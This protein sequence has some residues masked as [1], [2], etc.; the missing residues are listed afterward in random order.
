MYVEHRLLIR[1]RR[2]LWTLG[3]VGL[4]LLGVF[5]YFRIRGLTETSPGLAHEHA[6]DIVALE[7]ALGI[8]WEDELQALVTP[9]DFL[10][11]FANWIYIW[12]HWPV[13]IATMAWLIW[14]RRDVFLRLRDAMMISGLLGMIVFVTYPVAPPRLA[15]LGFVDTVTQSSNAYRVLQPPAFVNQYAAMPSLHSG[16]DL[17][18]GISIVTAASTVTLKV[19]GYAMPMLMAFA[20]VA[21][22]NHFLL[23]VVAGIAL[24]LVGHAGALAL[25]RRRQRRAV[26]AVLERPGPR[27]T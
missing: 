22:A 5:V 16:W 8:A 26:H 3:Q 4:V 11:T 1:R 20:V 14:R 9:V 6:Q 2:L 17:L 19:I 21:T 18:V 15:A 23:D 7:E 24:V 10:E 12:G 25:E 13:I 27:V